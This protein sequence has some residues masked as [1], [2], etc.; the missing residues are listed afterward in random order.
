MCILFT[1]PTCAPCKHI[2]PVI[3]DM[4]QD[5]EEISF[6]YVDITQDKF[7][8]DT[9]GIKYVPTMVAYYDNEEIARNT[10]SDAMGYYRI[11][12]TLRNHRG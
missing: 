1:S 10:G 8:S 3:E 9:C 2:K 11:L 4:M 7:L 12:K 5:F 6:K